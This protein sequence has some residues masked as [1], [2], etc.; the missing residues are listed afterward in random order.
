MFFR[1]QEGKTQEHA[2]SIGFGFATL[3]TIKLI[4]NL[5]IMLLKA[6]I[7]CTLHVRLCHKVLL[8]IQF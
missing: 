6:H 7:S 2:L 1:G 4:E 3:A 5:K 8:V